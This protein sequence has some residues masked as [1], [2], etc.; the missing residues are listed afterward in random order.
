MPDGEV[1]KL[2][3]ALGKPCSPYCLLPCY[4]PDA[5]CPRWQ[6]KGF[7]VAFKHTLYQLSLEAKSVLRIPDSRRGVPHSIG[8][9]EPDPPSPAYRWHTEDAQLRARMLAGFRKAE[10]IWRVVLRYDVNVELP[11]FFD[12]P[13]KHFDLPAELSAK[14]VEGKEDDDQADEVPLDSQDAD[15]AAELMGRLIKTHAE[16]LGGAAITPADDD[17]VLQRVLG[18]LF[19]DYH[20]RLSR[21]SYMRKYRFRTNSLLR[22]GVERAKSVLKDGDSIVAVFERDNGSLYWLVGH[23]EEARVAKHDFDEARICDDDLQVV[24]TVTYLPRSHLLLSRQDISAV[25]SAS[26]SS[27]CPRLRSTIAGPSFSCGGMS[28]WTRADTISTTIS[29]RVALVTA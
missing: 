14:G 13:W 29:T 22:D 7:F 20:S 16:H 19:R 8:R 4:A 28:R 11:G 2:T 23:I 5:G 24:P 15:D 1:Y 6:V 3:V 21:E 17:V 27:T 10:T 18:P 12:K 25:R 9:V 26:I